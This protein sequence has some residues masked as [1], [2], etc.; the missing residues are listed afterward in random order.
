MGLL[1]MFYPLYLVEQPTHLARDNS[2]QTDLEATSSSS[3][4]MPAYY[5]YHLF[6][7]LILI[8]LLVIVMVSAYYIF[9]CNLL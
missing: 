8:F 2:A 1:G 7:Y 3:M 6:I 9:I 5:R 4:D